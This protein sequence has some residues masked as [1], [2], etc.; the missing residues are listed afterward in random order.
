[1]IRKVFFTLL[2]S[3]LLLIPNM[4]DAAGF[5]GGSS[6]RSHG[7]FSSHGSSYSGSSHGSSYSGSS[8]R[9]SSSS[10]SST[11][12]SGSKSSSF[13]GGSSTKSSSHSS[14]GTSTKS[15]TNRYQRSGSFSGRTS[16]VSGKVY[17]GNTTKGY[18]RGHPVSVHHYYHAGYSPFGW[19]G[20][21]HG[22]TMGMFMGSMFHPWGA[23]YY[24]G[25]HYTNYG[26]SPIAWIID[27]IIVI[28]VIYL[29]YA[30]VRR[31]KS[32][33]TVYTRRF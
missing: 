8:T 16:T 12:S 14:G 2:L 25:G 19:F 7:S 9:R 24:T 4:V 33:R 6:S 21:Y 26:P 1:M 11:R 10:S 5:R 31:N 28:V 3:L 18:Y 17:S 23:T 30:L 22:F 29:L 20:Y 32:G 15:T 27:L 13:S